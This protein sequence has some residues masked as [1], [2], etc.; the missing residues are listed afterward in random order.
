MIKIWTRFAFI[1]CFV[2]ATGCRREATPTVNAVDRPRPSSSATDNDA[3]ADDVAADDGHQKMLAALEAIHSQTAEHHPFLGQRAL[4]EASSALAQSQRLVS[5][6]AHDKSRL[7]GMLGEELLR[8]GRTS[9]AIEH[10]QT[11][12]D[13]L[14]DTT[15]STTRTVRQYASF[16]LAIAYL[17]QGENANCVHCTT[18]ESCLL[19]IQGEGVHRDQS[20]SKAAVAHL[21]QVLKLD[22]T[23][24]RAR[25]L[26]N[27][28]H[29]TLG[30]YPDGVPLPF[31]IAPGVFETEHPTIRPFRNVAKA[32]QLDTVNLAG[33]VIVD[34]FD[35]DDY[36]DI[37]TSTWDTGGQLLFFRNQHD[38]TFANRTN[39]SGLSGILGGLNLIQADYD[40]DG[41]V[42]VLVLRGAWLE[43]AGQHPNSL[44]QNDGAGRFRDVTFELGLGDVHAPTQT[45]SWA[46]YDNDGDL[47]LYVGN[48]GLPCQLF[49]NDGKL[50][51]RDVAPSAGVQN[52]LLAKAVVWGDFNHDRFPDL[53]VSNLPGENRLYR[54]NRDGTFTDVANELGVRQPRYSF[55]AWFWDY[56]NDGQLDLYVAS[57]AP[58][59]QFVCADYLGQQVPIGKDCLYRGASDGTFQ[60]VASQSGL[61]RV[62]QPMGANFGDIDNN[63]YLDFYLGTGY[64]DYEGLMPNLLFRNR[65]GESFEDVTYAAR[66]G[67]LQKGH[68]VAFADLDNDGDVDVFSQMGGWFAGDGFANA[69][70][71]NPGADGHWIGVRLVGDQS[72]RSAIGAKIK[73]TVASEKGPK[74]IHRWVNSGGTFGANPLRQHIGVGAA[75]RVET[76]EIYWPTSDSTQTFH[77]LETGQ[78]IE[79]TE[80]ETEVRPITVDRFTFPQLAE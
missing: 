22:P 11:A 78:W 34:D 56:N 7:H 37:V 49:R 42:D 40:N 26:L 12:L 62:T 79:I 50:G 80:G 53:F 46:D 8:A 73:V 70:F 3:V 36:L 31:R 38:G 67:H 66:M 51:F 4:R 59:I 58:G 74:S 33:G 57:Y 39:E 10:I 18:G 23:D 6:S 52:H 17:R 75:T 64:V 32:L 25:W 35:G 16:R 48:E 15:D 76:V 2:L 41:D 29:M 28:A 72:N 69:V 63:G 61:T 5:I 65:D 43:A 21:E 13:A 54:N 44:L 68:G 20:G 71:E 19:P 77:D 1:G 60:E 27:I 14:P 47:D 45:A 55:S 9:E 24:L 30:S